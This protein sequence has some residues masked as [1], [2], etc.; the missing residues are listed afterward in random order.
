M[1]EPQKIMVT[2][3]GPYIVTGGV[4]LSDWF[5]TADEEGTSTGWEEGKRYPVGERYALCRCGKSKTMPFCDGTHKHEPFDGTETDNRKPFAERAWKL[6]GPGIILEDVLEFCVSARHCHLG[7]GTW[8][9]IADSDKP[10]V[11]QTAL[12]GVCNC[13]GGRLVARDAATGEPIEPVYEPSIGIIQDPVSF[14]SG[15]IWVRGGI[16]IEAVDGTL[17]EPRN[18]VALCR[19]GKSHNKP[20]CDAEHIYAPF[21]D[22]SLE[23]WQDSKEQ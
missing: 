15:P 23:E 12:Q 14:T 2:K 7:G 20:F 19:C 13:P 18:R 1:S 17:Y 21:R 16:P 4:P 6:E 11:R 5:I 3:D 10:E 8:G 9:L 22:P